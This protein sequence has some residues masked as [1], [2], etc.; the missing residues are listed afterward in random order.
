MRYSPFVTHAGLAGVLQAITSVM[1]GRLF[2][3]DG[4]TATIDGLLKEFYDDEFIAEGVNNKN[5][6]KDV[7]EDKLMDKTYGGR[8]VVYPFHT[9]RNRSPFAS[10]EYGLFAEADVQTVIQ[11]VVE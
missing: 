3:T 7:I 8:H 10:A 9:A 11:V 1:A 6:L 5:P 2:T 4:G